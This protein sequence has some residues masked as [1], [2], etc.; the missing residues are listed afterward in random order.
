MRDRKPIAITFLRCSRVATPRWPRCGGFRGTA[1]MKKQ[2]AALSVN[3]EFSSAVQPILAF[4]T[5]TVLPQVTI[6]EMP[7]DVHVLDR[8]DSPG[9]FK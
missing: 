1:T 9:A 6:E 5:G 3:G 8:M 7:T 4:L 2:V